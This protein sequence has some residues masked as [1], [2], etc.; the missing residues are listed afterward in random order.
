MGLL[1]KLF[2]G[3]SGGAG[4]SVE[5]GVRELN[6]LY[7]DPEVKAEGGISITGPRAKEVRAIGQRL[8]K[9]GGKAQMEAAREGVRAQHSWAA[10]N[11]ENIWSSMP[12]WKG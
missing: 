10:S 6:A 7:D 4:M 11:L 3:K 8:H 1:D 12:E 2:G 9:A 5:D